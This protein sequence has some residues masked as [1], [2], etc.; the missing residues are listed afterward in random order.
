MYKIMKNQNAI[1]MIKILKTFNYTEPNIKCVV[2]KKTIRVGPDNFVPEFEI[3]ENSGI[4]CLMINGRQW[5]LYNTNTYRQ[6]A[7]LFSHYYIASGNV[8][9]TGLGFA[10]RENWLLK[11]PKVKTITVIEKN[12]TLINYHK[13]TNPKLFEKIKI[14]CADATEY[15]GECDTLLIDHY[16]NDNMEYMINDVKNI[17]E[18]NIKCNK[19]WFWHLETKLLADSY[20]MSEINL[21]NDF[22]DG[23][24][25]YDTNKFNNIITVYNNLKTAGGLKWL[26]ELSEGELKLFITMYTLFFKYL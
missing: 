16:E 10:L 1:L 24:F 21:A 25:K 18:N 14:I 11:N 7:Q 4:K 26:P 5:M 3:L 19:M 15:K 6:V 17:C 13:K 22:N 9:T 23:K 12:Q 20:G 8:I 2:S